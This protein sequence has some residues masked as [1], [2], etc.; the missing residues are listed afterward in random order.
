MERPGAMG[1]IERSSAAPSPVGGN[2]FLLN[3]IKPNA[4][5]AISIATCVADRFAFR[6]AASNKGVCA[7]G[8]VTLSRDGFAHGW[9][10][11]TSS[12]FEKRD[13]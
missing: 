4:V 1:H 6:P 12:T 9:D 10:S 3:P 13:E 8:M 11:V 5:P 7:D 2:N